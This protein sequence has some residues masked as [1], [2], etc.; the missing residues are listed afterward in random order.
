MIGSMWKLTGLILVQ[1]SSAVRR[2]FVRLVGAVGRQSALHKE[3]SGFAIPTLGRHISTFRGY[4]ILF[5]IRNPTYKSLHQSFSYSFITILPPES[6]VTARFCL[7]PADPIISPFVIDFHFRTYKH[8][9]AIL[10]EWWQQCIA[11]WEL[12]NAACQ[13]ICI[14]VSWLSDFIFYPKPLYKSL[15]QSFF[16]SFI[17][18]LPSESRKK[19]RR[20]AEESR[21]WPR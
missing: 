18:I 7:I 1:D 15:H 10:T 17:T 12:L 3:N 4:R 8:D 6:G 9:L 19:S 5:S 13:I 2:L 14:H 11:W 16:Y 20:T 21:S